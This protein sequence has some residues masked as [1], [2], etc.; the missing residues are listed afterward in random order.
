MMS[1]GWSYFPHAMTMQD[2]RDMREALRLAEGSYSPAEEADTE[3][4]AWIIFR[5]YSRGMTDPERLAAIAVFLSSSRVFSRHR[6][7]AD[8]GGVERRRIPAICA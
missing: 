6:Q 5:Y 7:R 2:L 1:N 8:A 4:L 3:L